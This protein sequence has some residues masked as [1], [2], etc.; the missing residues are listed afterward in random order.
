M[1]SDLHSDLPQEHD[2]SWKVR[3]YL[4]GALIGLA[5]GLIS[6]YFYARVSEENGF[7]RPNRIPTIDALKLAVSLL[8]VIR[9]ITDLGA[10]RGN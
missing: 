8:S 5:V 1:T 3:V 10:R 9:Q 4:V 7:E 2:T 6:A